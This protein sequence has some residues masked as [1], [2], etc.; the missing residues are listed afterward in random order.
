MTEHGARMV[1][2]MSSH[3][4]SAVTGSKDAICGVRKILSQALITRKTRSSFGSGAL[5]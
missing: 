1:S 2:R 4:A 5:S 3:S